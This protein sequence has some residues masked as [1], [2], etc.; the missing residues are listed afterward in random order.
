M[1]SGAK[2]PV[3]STWRKC[4]IHI[5]SPASHNYN[6]RNVDENVDPYEDFIIKLADSDCGLIGINDYCSIDGYLE[7]C[8]RL[9]E[10]LETR[11]ESNRR[12]IHYQEAMKKLCGPNILILP[13]I[14]FRANEVIQNRRNNAKGSPINF[15]IIFS[16]DIETEN[17]HHWLQ[18]LRDGDDK[19]IFNYDGNNLS[20]IHVPFN[21]TVDSLKKDFDKKHLI[22][23]VYDGHGGIDDADHGHLPNLKSSMIG[24]SHIIET[25][26]NNIINKFSNASDEYENMGIIKLKGKKY[27]CI[28]GSDFHNKQNDKMGCLKNSESKPADKYCWIKA[29]PTFDGF[30]MIVKEPDRA[31]IGRSPKELENLKANPTHFLSG[32]K[33]AKHDESSNTPKWFDCDIPLNSG[34]VAIIGNKGSGKSALADIIALACD[35]GG[36]E[37]FSFLNKKKFRTDKNHLA[38][39]YEATVSWQCSTINTVKLDD[40]P[41]PSKEAKVRYISQGYLEKVCNDLIEGK[42]HIF[43]EEL[44]KVAFMYIDNEDRLGKDAMSDLIT[45]RTEETYSHI[46]QLRVEL[47]EVNSKLSRLELK[48]KEHYRSSLKSSL[49]TFRNKLKEKNKQIDSLKEKLSSNNDSNEQE[50]IEKIDKEID[51]LL[52]VIKRGKNELQGITS[53]IALAEKIL[54]RLESVEAFMN[55]NKITEECNTL[56]LNED[57]IISFK[58]NKTPIEA[59][60]QQLKESKQNLKDAE[61][62]NSHKL[63]SLRNQRKKI[64]EKEG[65]DAQR[66]DHTAQELN[67]CNKEKI[68]IEQEIE[69]Y[70]NKVVYLNEGLSNDLKKIEEERN[71]ISMSIYNNYSKIIK[72]YDELFKPLQ[73]QETTA[74]LSFSYCSKIKQDGILRFFERYIDQRTNNPF[75]D[76]VDSTSEKNISRRISS[77]NFNDR[78]S[79]LEFVN[80]VYADLSEGMKNNKNSFLHNLYLKSEMTHVEAYDYVFGFEYLRPE[81]SLLLDDKDIN[82]LSPGERGAL[83]LNFY[84]QLDKSNKPIIIDQPEENL[85][86]QSIYNYLVPVFKKVK[87]IDKL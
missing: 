38:K 28:K 41:D 21:P 39:Q 66:K 71:D 14:E 11:N 63:D 83:F 36:E 32:I 51:N 44:E 49:E 2:F 64:M 7:V 9:N 24:K 48:G 20:E 23:M 27:P 62:S 56:E 76:I 59:K 72:V 73:N 61:N 1:S 57:E 3:G 70:D 85:D 52:E 45:F 10:Y 81:Y 31:Y 74:D 42:N 54:S 87:K 43:Q 19:S 15:H 47:H 22:V 53:H 30:S 60:L 82:K 18:N 78:Q 17:I 26:N 55:K 33:I 65:I 6:K 37:D 86:N 77:C 13:V 75:F 5:H 35:A 4:D 58:I 67:K 40:N 46:R 29:D 80:N 34:M 12:K 16:N 8:K 25:S 68:E 50:Q 69:K 84:L 79:I